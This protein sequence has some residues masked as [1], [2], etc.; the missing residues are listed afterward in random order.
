MKEVVRPQRTERRDQRRLPPEPAVGLTDV[1]VEGSDVGA[2]SVEVLVGGGLLQ[3][4]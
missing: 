1:L 3:H 4:A 2:V